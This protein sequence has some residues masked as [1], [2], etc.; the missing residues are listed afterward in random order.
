MRK[1][2]ITLMVSTA[3]VISAVPIMA[4]AAETG[5]ATLEELVVTARK[6]SENILDVPIAVSAMSEKDMVARGIESLQDVARFTPGMNVDQSIGGTLRSDRSFQQIIIRGLNPSALTSPTTSVFINGTPVATSDFLHNIDD[7]ERV[8][9]L[10]G[11]Q[12]AY[13]GRN[14]FAGA[15]NVIAKSAGDELDGNAS[16]NIGSRNTRNFSANLTVPIIAD[17]LS[18]RGG[19][20]YQS[21]DGSYKNAFNRSETLGDITTEAGHLAVTFKPVEN[22]TIK[23]FALRFQDRDGAPATGMLLAQPGSRFDQSNCTVAGVPYIC[24][25][26]PGLI[27]SVSPS[28]ITKVVQTSNGLNLSQA[29]LNDPGGVLKKDDL[30]DGFGLLRNA[31]H[32]DLNIEYAIPSLGLTATYLM[33][34]NRNNWSEVSD[35]SNFDGSATGQVP[36]YNGFPFMVQQKA[37]DYSHEF[38]VTSD[39]DKRLRG[40]A[41][42]SYVSRYNTSSAGLAGIGPRALA[43]GGVTR[44]K[45][46]GVFA[47][48]SYD[49]LPE[50]TVTAEGR[51]QEAHEYAFNSAYVGLADNNFS[52]FVPRVSVQ[53]NF[54]PDVMAYATYSKGINPGA[55][56]T[57]FSTIPAASRQELLRLGILGTT[58][59]QPEYITNYELGFKGKFL[60]GRATIS[61]D[62]YY[63]QWTNQLTSR[64][65]IWSPTD[66]TNPYNVV[67]GPQY[68]PTNISAYLY[69]YTDN[70]SEST[71]KGVEVEANLIVFD[72][73]TVNFAGA[74]N[75]TRF[76]KY[77]CQG[78]CLPNPTTPGVDTSGKYLPNASKLSF[79]AGIEYR[80][81]IDMFGGGEFFIR[82]DYIYKDGVYIQANNTTK[83]P[84]FKLTNIRAGIQLEHIR[85]EAYVNNV[86]NTRTP[87]S[88]F[89]ATNF[90]TFGPGVV[91]VGLPELITAGVKL[92][93][94]Y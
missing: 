90:Q 26:I 65:Y 35:L 58:I 94:T 27:R 46:K 69:N 23:A 32:G 29:F 85:A 87:V 63:D 84:N 43:P 73:V 49:L 91:Q 79:N 39:P 21:H 14:T 77:L 74:V 52:D 62:I 81:N 54:T 44:S 88:G 33:A 5:G 92:S 59:V 12:S 70:S 80:N 76:D 68:N 72:H 71:A 34:Y 17:M 11:P 10:K 53:Y 4:S 48:L 56:N 6:V 60:D 31:W 1:S 22:L 50:L 78:G 61:A 30:V 40:M 42:V 28:Q 24:G 38:R 47:S 55:F 2:K 37:H 25:T 45:T 15:V 36:G 19:Y 16:V 86:F 67:G 18:V 7:V 13:F 93:Y 83:T 75:D 9:V 89:Q 8:E 82:G 20:S 41:G 57:Q 3:I 66:P 64:Q 51:Y